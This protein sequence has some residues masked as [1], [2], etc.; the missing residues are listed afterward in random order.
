MAKLVNPELSQLSEKIDLLLKL[1][2]DFAQFGNSEIARVCGTLE[3]VNVQT[4]SEANIGEAVERIRMMLDYN[5]KEIQKDAKATVE[6]LERNRQIIEALDELEEGER[7]EKLVELFVEDAGQSEDIDTFKKR[8]AS[9]EIDRRKDFKQFVQEVEESIQDGDI[10]ELE[11]FLEEQLVEQAE[12][13]FAEDE[14]EDESITD[15][16]VAGFLNSL[17]EPFEKD[18]NDSGEE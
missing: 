5:A 11:A 3:K 6:S 9:E 1:N 10:I 13:K 16:D 8:I 15:E 17:K 14:R 2:E 12:Q 4:D 7:K 18:K